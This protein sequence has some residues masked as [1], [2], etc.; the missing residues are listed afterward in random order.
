MNANVYFVCIHPIGGTSNARRQSVSGA[1]RRTGLILAKSVQLPICRPY[2]TS[3]NF[4]RLKLIDR[5]F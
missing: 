5:T 1:A 4:L 3:H 2:G